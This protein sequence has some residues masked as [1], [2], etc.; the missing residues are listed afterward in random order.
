M[1]WTD[2]LVPALAVL[3][4][5]P[6]LTIAWLAGHRTGDPAR[7]QFAAGLALVAAI[8]FLV[9][10]GLFSQVAGIKFL[11]WNVTFLLAFGSLVVFR[12]FV[13]LVLPQRPVQWLPF[14]LAS[15]LFYAT[16][17]ALA[18]G[19]TPPVLDFRSSLA[20]VLGTV[21]YL[22]GA[23]TPA[24]ALWRHRRDLPAWLSVLVAQLVIIL[25]P[26]S[27][28]SAVWE[29][30]RWVAL[31]PQTLSA[32]PVVFLV[33]FALVGREQVR[34]FPSASTD[35]DTTERAR[36]LVERFPLQRITA[37]EE[38]ILAL[39]LEGRKNSEIAAQLGLSA[40]TVKNH[41]YNLYQ[42]LGTDTRLELAALA[43]SSE[44]DARP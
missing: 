33:F 8:I 22:L 30:F 31:V 34:Q 40:H 24:L 16:T 17:L 2:L 44:T 35:N 13:H 6:P 7:R 28:V 18:F 5:L 39:L 43:A 10:A 29:T 20:S 11:F 15:A 25:L 14:W 9:S 21:Y 42:K 1:Y 41:I 3:A 12:R 23:L 38:Q 19:M 26:L 4:S 32:I 36:R 37:R 27:V